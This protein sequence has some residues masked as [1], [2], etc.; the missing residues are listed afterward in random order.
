MSKFARCCYTRSVDSYSLQFDGAISNDSSLLPQK[1]LRLCFTI[2]EKDYSSIPNTINHTVLCSSDQQLPWNLRR[3]SEVNPS[4]LRSIV[5]HQSPDIEVLTN[6]FFYTLRAG[7][8]IF[9]SFQLRS[10]VAYVQRQDWPRVYLLHS[11]TID[12]HQEPCHICA[13]TWPDK[14]GYLPGQGWHSTR[15]VTASRREYLEKA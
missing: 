14:R 7:K 5:N 13:P 9:K 1:P 8:Q 15:R 10:T 6:Q 2:S 4:F 12:L 3:L 11:V